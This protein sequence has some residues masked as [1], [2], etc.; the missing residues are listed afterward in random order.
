M[1][2]FWLWIGCPAYL[3]YSL[4]TYIDYIDGC[5]LRSLREIANTA[6]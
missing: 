5:P 3:A 6:S 1:N 4:I 2:V